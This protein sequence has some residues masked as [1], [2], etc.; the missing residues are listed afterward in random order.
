[1]NHLKQF[2][3]PYLLVCHV[4]L[5]IAQSGHINFEWGST[6]FSMPNGMVTQVVE[7]SFGFL[8]LAT[9]EGLFRYDGYEFKVYRHDVH[10]STTLSHPSVNRILEDHENNIWVATTYGLNRHDRR[11]GAFEEILPFPKEG[12]KSKGSNHV[13]NIFQDSRQN[14]WVVCRRY[15]L[16]YELPTRHFHLVQQEDVPEKRYPIRCF[17]EEKSGTI[18]AGTDDG[19]LKINPGDSTFQHILPEQKRSSLFNNNIRGICAEDDSTFWLGTKGGLIQ[20]NHHSGKI[21]RDI[22]PDSLADTPIRALLA[23]TQGNLCL[24]FDKNGIGVY[25]HTAHTFHHMK[26]QPNQVNGLP[27]HTITSF[28]EDRYKNIWVSTSNGVGKLKIDSSG[29]KMV[30]NEM[31][32]ENIDNHTIR[33]MQDSEGGIWSKTPEGFFYIKKGEA[34]SRRIKELA[35]FKE[36]VARSWFLEDH[37]GGIWISVGERGIY[38]RGKKEPFFKKMPLSEDL[39]TQGINRIL[40]DARDKETIW[41]GSVKG[42]CRLNWKTGEERWYRPQDDQPTVSSNQV[43]IFEQFQDDEIWL[44]YTYSNSIGRFD[45]KS[46]TFELH[47]PPSDKSSV[48]E[49]AVKDIAIGDDGNL[50]LATLYGLTNFNIHTK[51]F[52]IYGKKEGMLENELS[53]VL[54]DRQKQVWVC[55]N[56]FFSHF[57]PLSKTFTNYDV[58]QEVRHFHSK[59]RDVAADGT[60]LLGSINGIYTFHPQRI[61]KNQL[62]PR[63][64]LTDFKVKN[65]THL[66]AQ[67]LEETT[68]IVLSHDEN[69]LTF[70]FSGLHFVNPKANRYKCML[71][72]YDEGWRQL[73]NEHK[74]SYTNLNP[75]QYTFRTLAANSDGVWSKKGLVIQLHITP[76]FWQTRWFKSLVAL[77]LLSIGYTIY[78]NKQAQL[79][80]QRQKE[81]AEQSAEYKTQFLADVS[82]EIRT[83]MNAIIG[84][85]KMLSDS[86]LDK[87]QAR[88]TNA[89]HQSSQNLLS[90]INDLLDHT[91]LRAG[92]FRFVEKQFT[93]AEIINHLHEIFKIKTDEKKLGLE[94]N[95]PNDLPRELIGDPLRL[96]QILTNLL[97]N[98]I[99][100]TEGGKIWLHL[101]MKQS[102][103][104]KAIIRFEV[105]DT[106][107]GIPED[108][109]NSIFENFS[110]AENSRISNSGTGLGLSIA[111]QL[112]ERQGGQIFIESKLGQGTRFWFDLIFAKPV[113]TTKPKGKA[114]FKAEL[115][116]LKLLVVEDNPFNQMLILEI[117]KKYAPMTQTEVAENG[118]LALEKLKQQT[119]DLIIMDVKMPVLDGYETTK[120][121]RH[122]GKRWAQ[123]PIL[124]VT[125]NAL[126]EQL[127]KCKASGMDDYITKPIDDKL[128][129]DKI[130]KLTSTRPHIN[131]N[132]LKKLLANDEKKVEQFLH[133]FKSETPKQL[134]SLKGFISDGKWEQASIMAHTLKSQC[135]YLGLEKMADLVY[136]LER[137]AEAEEG[138]DTLAG[139]AVEL[140]NKLSDIIVQELSHLSS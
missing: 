51:E 136:E 54:I 83:P 20:W 31:G 5:L 43:A 58:G 128:L 21:E 126:P 111:R 53:S 7:D 29:F 101:E 9:D 30:R 118:K 134:S 77:V 129:L 47:V 116:E 93:L 114:P 13:N 81:L 38:R 1:M 115:P 37:E 78:K 68:D 119:F 100:F 19:L 99:K 135:Q 98:A 79:I 41:V 8:W 22:L 130:G 34:G 103:P 97:G 70:A 42:L 88:F 67:A 56:R 11:T 55:G 85:S 112:V 59:S 74:I 10:D 32:F 26:Y 131:L 107:I 133:I 33:V 82:H 109:L 87:K 64:V 24:A 140:E 69:D 117:L 28:F 17:F 123:I 27:A 84:L 121:I 73:G 95:I 49:G 25:N 106:G 12:R 91:K 39:S 61:K 60:M 62:P 40:P 105:G 124:A 132:R 89:I 36:Q 120:A 75:G 63:V 4:G 92:K 52:A 71:V 3:L 2:I 65:E 94:I 110:Q 122:S 102:P 80:L 50:W 125:A 90:I 108:Q 23:D 6:K 35:P 76:P 137:L 15:L 18:W 45:K 57:D 139:L 104:Q 96:T 138:L 86:G 66:L 113:L 127:E 16:R 48:L 14:L 46:E 72:G 44:Y